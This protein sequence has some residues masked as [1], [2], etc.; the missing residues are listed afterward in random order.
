MAEKERVHF[1]SESG[2][3]V[4]RLAG[5]DHRA[6]KGS[7]VA[8]CYSQQAGNRVKTHRRATT[9]LN[10]SNS[11]RIAEPMLGEAGDRSEAA[12]PPLKEIPPPP[13]PHHQK[14]SC[15]TATTATFP[16][17]RNYWGVIL[18]LRSRPPPS[19]R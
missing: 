10:Q 14:T 11:R 13:P 16:V 8:L 2:P 15:A 7:L 9:S 19:R 1:C 6:P 18:R 17:A 12:E 3:T 4:Y 5:F